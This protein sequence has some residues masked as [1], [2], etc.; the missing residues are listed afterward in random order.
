LIA[1][2]DAIIDQ[3][4]FA[5]A[6]WGIAVTSLDS[7]RTLYAHRADRLMQ[8]ASTAK[9]FTAAVSLA[10]FGP[11]Y[12]IPTRLL[13]RGAIRNGR[14]DGSLILRGMGDPT[15]GTSSS[16]DW[17]DQ[18]AT[19]L[20]AR[21]VTRVHGDLLAD[22]SYYSGP[23]FGTGWEAGDLQSWFAAPSSALGVQ[24]NIVRVTVRPGGAVGMPAALDFDPAEARPEVL[25]QLTTILPRAAGDINLYRAPGNATLYAFGTIAANAP[26]QHF[27]LALVDPARIAGIDG[28]LRWPLRNGRDWGRLRVMQ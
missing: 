19:Q 14:L 20:A 4:R 28:S 23:P 9:L 13:A 6:A 2:I 25:G 18:L 7:G 22:D 24:E 8:P 16:V 3:P 12:R 10:T 26:P 15:L 11:D 5:S 27:K 1:Q 17:A 21:G